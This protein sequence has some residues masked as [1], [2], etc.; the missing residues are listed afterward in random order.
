MFRSLTF[1]ACAASA[2][3]LNVHTE[4]T[5]AFDAREQTMIETLRPCARTWWYSNSDSVEDDW[6]ACKADADAAFLA[7]ISDDFPC[8]AENQYLLDTLL[9]GLKNESF[10]D[11]VWEGI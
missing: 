11:K 1:L 7:G 8:I 5:N 3:N 6:N 9:W 10:W 2:L 4:V